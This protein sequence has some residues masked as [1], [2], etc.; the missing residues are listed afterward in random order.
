[1]NRQLGQAQQICDHVA[2]QR[3]RWGRHAGF[4]DFSQEQVLDALVA[5]HE[6]G[7]FEQLDEALDVAAANRRAGAAEAR[8]SK[9]RKRLENVEAQLTAALARIEELEG[10]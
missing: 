7:M 2:K 6:E 9:T 5:L 4:G 10:E 1:M 3:K 8:E